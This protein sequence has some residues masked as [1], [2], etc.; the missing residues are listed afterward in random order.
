LA[1]EAAL[2]EAEELIAAMNLKLFENDIIDDIRQGKG[3][4][5]ASTFT[6]LPEQ[7]ITFRFVLHDRHKDASFLARRLRY[8][9]HFG[10][11]TNVDIGKERVHYFR[12]KPQSW[13]VRLKTL[14]QGRGAAV[15]A[16]PDYEVTLQIKGRGGK[17]IAETPFKQGI[18]IRSYHDKKYRVDISSVEFITFITAFLIALGFAIN[19]HFDEVTHFFSFKDWV[20]PFLWGFGL[21]QGKNTFMESFKS[22]AQGAGKVE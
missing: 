9:W 7:I 17:E 13:W 19:L 1:S 15:P 22:I 5:E 6:P 11:K 4:I 20:T 3:S 16:K 8:E 14:W 10:D 21:D 12:T 2:Q 18:F